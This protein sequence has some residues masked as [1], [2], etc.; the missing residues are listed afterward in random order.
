MVIV[1]R[2]GGQRRT[3]CVGKEAAARDLLNHII[4]ISGND[5][6]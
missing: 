5:N 4:G 6:G 3:G 1:D 2:Y